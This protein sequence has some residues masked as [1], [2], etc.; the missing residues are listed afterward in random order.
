MMV[1]HCDDAPAYNERCC[2]PWY[3]RGETE[4]KSNDHEMRRTKVVLRWY[5][6]Q[7]GTGTA[8]SI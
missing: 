5:L 6:N 1:G 2:V 4:K 3:K 8:T 7:N